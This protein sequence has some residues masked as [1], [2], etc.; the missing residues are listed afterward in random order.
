MRTLSAAV[1]GLGLLFFVIGGIT[2]LWGLAWIW[3]KRGVVGVAVSVFTVAPL[4]LA[5][6]G[7][8]VLDGIWLPGVLDIVALVAMWGTTAAVRRINTLDALRVS[9]GG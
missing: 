3:A 8:G 5:P 7:M 6:V 1:S 4:V 9:Q 2:W